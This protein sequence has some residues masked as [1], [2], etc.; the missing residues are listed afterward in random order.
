MSELYNFGVCIVVAIVGASICLA[1]GLGIAH[2]AG[3]DSLTGAFAIGVP[4]AL[5]FG[6]FFANALADRFSRE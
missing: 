6:W 1:I 2:L 5:L 3:I 4:L